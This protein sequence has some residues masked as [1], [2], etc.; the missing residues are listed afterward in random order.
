M[1]VSFADPDTDPVPLHIIEQG[2]IDD[3]LADKSSDITAWV[4]ASGFTGAIGQAVAVPGA[5]GT[6]SMALAGYGN[7]TTRSRARFHLAAAVPG[8]LRAHTGLL[9]ACPLTAWKR[10]RW[11]G[12]WPD[13][14]LTATPPPAARMHGWHL[15]Q[16]LM[17]RDCWRLP[18]ARFWPAT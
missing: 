5:E 11:A 15:M 18:K 14:A 9:Q 6:V 1:S 4:T 8:C 7:S 2:G 17:S 12:C 3:W 16:H 13:T 10:K